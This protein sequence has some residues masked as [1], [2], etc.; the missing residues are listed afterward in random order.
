MKNGNPVQAILRIIL[1][2]LGEVF[3]AAIFAAAIGLGSQMLNIDGDLG[4]HITLG[5][6]ILDTTKIP[7]SDVFSFT[8]YGDP[9]TPHEWLSDVFFS[10]VHKIAGLDGVVWLTALIISL[11]AF[12]SASLPVPPSL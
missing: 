7:T 2:R 11:A 1:P 10:I 4:R 5:D 9:L 6:S 8:K 12:Q 3:F